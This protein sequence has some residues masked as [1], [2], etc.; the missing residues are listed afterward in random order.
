MVTQPTPPAR[1]AVAELLQRWNDGDR[2]ALDQITPLVY[3]ELKRL[4]HDR[5][6]KERYGHTLNTTGLVHEA[7]MRLADIERVEWNDRNHFFSM[8]SRVM[9]RVLVDHARRRN[10]SKRE[11]GRNVT[12]DEEQLLVTAEQADTVL[13]LDEAIHRLED[14]HPR[15]AKVVEL[16]YFGGLRQSEV[17]EVLAVSQPTVARDLRFALAWLGREWARS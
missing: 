1:A 3:D 6:R 12:L 5:L 17:G 9:R 10:A 2:R 16:H 14:A 7:Y 11:G 4:A 8:A 15:P 13:E